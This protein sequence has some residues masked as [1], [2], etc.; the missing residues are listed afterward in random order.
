[1]HSSA[2]GGH[3]GMKATYQRVKR[4]FQ[5]PNLKKY[6]EQF[7]AKCATCQRNKSEHRHYLGLLSPL[8]IL[9]IEWS[10]I[11]IDFIEGLPKSGTKNVIL[12]S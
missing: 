8:P 1:L 3:L 12:G 10:F 2:I 11:S 7:V 5:W 9:E 6:V 4:I